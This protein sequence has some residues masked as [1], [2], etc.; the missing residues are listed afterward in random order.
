MVDYM[1]ASTIY[2]SFFDAFLL[3]SHY[4]T[5]T[6]QFGPCVLES[7]PPPL[8]SISQN[9]IAFLIRSSN[10]FSVLTPVLPS[11]LF[12]YL[13]L[14]KC[15]IIFHCCCFYLSR[16][17]FDCSSLP[18]PASCSQQHGVLHCFYSPI[19]LLHHIFSKLIL[20]L[21]LFYLLDLHRLLLMSTLLIQRALPYPY[22]G[23]SIYRLLPQ[24][25]F[26]CLPF[27]TPTLESEFQNRQPPPLNLLFD[28][29]IPP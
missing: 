26:D 5:P 24:M 8:I 11:S 17:F 6:C 20:V 16:S 21:H 18:P 19:T 4:I 23:S 2:V 25:S 28:Y 10:P 14:F 9:P 29:L 22:L 13:N 27:M 1:S 3:S 15:I 12:L 7:S